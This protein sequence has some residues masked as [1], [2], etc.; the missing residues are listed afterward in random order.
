ML[1]EPTLGLGLAK[2]A[3]RERMIGIFSD[4]QEARRAFGQPLAP[5]DPAGLQSVDRSDLAKQLSP[6]FTGAP[7][8][9]VFVILGEEG[10][11]KSWLVASSWVR[12]NPSP[13]LVVFTAGEL[14]APMAL[15][16]LEG[17][18]ITKLASQAEG[19]TPAGRARWRRRFKSWRANPQPSDPRLVVFVDGLNQATDF[20]WPRWIDA[21]GKFLATPW[22]ASDC[23]DDIAPL[24][25]APCAIM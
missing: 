5:L 20:E 13:L 12:S 24:R 22:W 7:G 16:D 18:I 2:A 8:D 9:Q 3:N 17:T 25:A 23:H 11:G 14:H 10:T 15:H 21:A 6:A 1:T 19:D 4:R